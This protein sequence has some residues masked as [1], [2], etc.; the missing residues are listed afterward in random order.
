MSQRQPLTTEEKT[1]SYAK[2]YDLEMTP[3]PDEKMK[4]LA[5]G[6]IDPANAL[7]IRNRNDLFRPGYL[8]CEIGYCIMPDGSGFLA[9]LTV[10][11]DVKP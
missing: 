10:M 2:Y 1:H 9:N 6:P 5:A 4:M 3:I 8:D 11:P 7:D